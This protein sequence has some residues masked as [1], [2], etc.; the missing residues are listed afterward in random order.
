VAGLI[1]SVIGAF[2]GFLSLLIGGFG[3]LINAVLSLLD[4]FNVS[5]AFTLLKFDKR[6]TFIPA[7]VPLSGD[8]PVNLTLALLTANVLDNELVA[9]GQLA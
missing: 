5:L 2:T 9:E 1:N 4:L 3:G 7:N 8:A 6:Q